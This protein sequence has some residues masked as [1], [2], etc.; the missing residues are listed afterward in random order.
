MMDMFRVPLMPLTGGIGMPRGR[1]PVLEELPLVDLFHRPVM[2]DML[3]QNAEMVRCRWK[4]DCPD[5]IE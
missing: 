3:L 2:L 5:I 4:R 1:V